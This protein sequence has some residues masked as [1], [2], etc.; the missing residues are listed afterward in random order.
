MIVFLTLLLGLVAGSHPVTVQVSPEV[1]RIELQLDGRR[2]GS[3]DA[4]PWTVTVPF[5]E[6]LVPHELVAIAFGRNGAELGRARQ[7]INVPRAGAEVGLVLVRDSKGVPIAAEVTWDGLYAGEPTVTASFDGTPLSIPNPRRIALPPHSLEETHFL[8]VEA[9]FGEAGLATAELAYG[10]GLA[11]E[12]SS[13]LT[14]VPVELRG[15]RELPTLEK[16]QG[17]LE[18][19]GRPVRIVAAEEGPGEAFFVREQSAGAI[20][21]GL[22]RPAARIVAGRVDPVLGRDTRHALALGEKDFLHVYLPQPFQAEHLKA[23]YLAFPS[24]GPFPSSDLGVYWLLTEVSSKA[25]TRPQ[26]EIAEAVAVAGL[27][28]AG[29]HRRRVVVLALGSGQEPASPLDPARARELLAALRVPLVV[30]AIGPDAEAAAEAGA[31]RWPGARPVPHLGRLKS[32]VADLRERLG[33]QRILWV[34]GRHLPQSLT[35]TAQAQGVVLAGA[36]TSP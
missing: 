1:A 10:G 22:A 27:A 12:A 8:A 5:G 4:A 18:K 13:G 24:G 35:L 33:R 17:W 20:L 30:W 7:W 19:D 26:Q 34:E 21:R 11:D 32:A 25:V 9:R 15:R 3:A 31:A 16:L 28:A 14:A 36:E 29:R 2:V 23:R 6:A